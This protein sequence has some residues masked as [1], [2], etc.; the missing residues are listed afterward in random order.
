MSSVLSDGP[1]NQSTLFD[2]SRNEASY[3]SYTNLGQHGGVIHNVNIGN[4][5][6]NYR[7]ILSSPLGM[8]ASSSSIN[9]FNDT[10]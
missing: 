5:T 3:G 6:T 1:S 2:Y 4:Q 8:L 7:S 9:E 10:R